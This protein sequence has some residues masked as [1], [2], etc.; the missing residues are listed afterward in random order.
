MKKIIAS[1]L[2]IT[3]IV[4]CKKEI[5]K[6]VDTT[7]SIANSISDSTKK[8]NSVVKK[9]LKIYQ[10]C[11][12]LTVSGTKKEIAVQTMLAKLVKGG[13]YQYIE[14][15][16]ISNGT[17]YGILGVLKVNGERNI[18]LRNY[19]PKDST[20]TIV[21]SNSIDLKQFRSFNGGK[22]FS[23]ISDTDT[24][25]FICFHDDAFSGASKDEILKF[26]QSNLKTGMNYMKNSSEKSKNIPKVGDGGILTIDGCE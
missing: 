18:D 17:D 9:E 23:T 15:Y 3:L 1:L 25:H 11:G 14:Y 7:D 6:P 2:I 26:Y 4:G 16:N 10:S 24:V 13:T 19:S 5:E 22:D 12:K 8:S 21:D 20:L